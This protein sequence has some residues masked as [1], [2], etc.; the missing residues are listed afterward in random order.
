[1]SHLETRC[2]IVR[3][4]FRVVHVGYLLC[5]MLKTCSELQEHWAPAGNVCQL[6][7]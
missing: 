2:A 7:V 4:Q 5:Y 1:M 6:L 3:Q